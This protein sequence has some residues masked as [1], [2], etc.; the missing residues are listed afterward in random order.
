MQ[1]RGASGGATAAAGRYRSGD[2]AGALET[3]SAALAANPDDVEA[4]HLKAMA[5]GRLGRI[6]E[7]E[8]VFRDAARA[9]PQKAAVL[10]NFGNALQQAGKSRE[11]IA[12]YRDALAADPKLANAWLNLGLALLSLDDHDL[13][14]EALGRA[15]ALNPNLAGAWSGLG[16]IK[17]AGDLSDEALH[18]FERAL[19]LNSGHAPARIRKA[20]ILGSLGRTGEALAA[21]QPLVAAPNPPAVALRQYG[22]TLRL[23]GRPDEA[24]AAFRRA[25]AQDP[26]RADAHGD[27]ARLLWETGAED[28]FLDALDDALAVNPT[29]ELWRLRGDLSFLSGRVDGAEAAGRAVLEMKPEDP[30]GF[31]LIAKARRALG[32]NQGARQFAGRAFRYA[33]DD[34][35]IRHQYAEELL[36]AGDFTAARAIVDGPAPRPHLQKQIA[37]RALALRCLGD[38]EYRRWYDYDRFTAQI[39]IDAPRGYPSVEAFNR[40]FASFIA[41]LHDATTRPLDQTLYGGTQSYGRLWSRPEPVVAAFREAMLAAA[42]RY[43]DRLPDD[44]SHEFLSRKTSAL[45]CAGAWS[46]MLS[47]GGGHV[48]H[49]HPA[50]WISASYY[51]AAPPETLTAS[52]AG[53]LR[54]GAS[55]VFGLSLS[56]ERYFAPQPGTV[57]FFPSYIWH[58]VDPFHA[59]D[60]RITAPF[61]LAPKSAPR[62]GDAKAQQRVPQ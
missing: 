4:L 40:E 8:P 21:L 22:A 25:L 28:S 37:L 52:K 49:I 29:R 33:P 26:Y 31:A 45:A 6:D 42:E 27:L 9:H 5:L 62:L 50:G 20:E 58:G 46:V 61:D 44:N 34:F 41:T 12:V 36:R 2:F 47:S 54:L 16:A 13:A 1:S 10:S 43:V 23:A 3:A 53:H 59:A 55:G 24:V 57:V 19:S 15:I 18:C 48:D 32:D 56:A 30:H 60:I 14:E 7:A 17:A 38:P 35:Q 51:V 11:A 39:E